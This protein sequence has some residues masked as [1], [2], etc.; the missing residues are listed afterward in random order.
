MKNK[1]AVYETQSPLCEAEVFIAKSGSLS[2]KLQQLGAR[3]GDPQLH[4]HPGAIM[5]RL[6]VSF[7]CK[8][9]SCNFSD[10]GQISQ[11]LMVIF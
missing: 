9:T 11:K 6:M 5:L 4:K 8:D 3:V 7:K 1:K 2:R 10:G